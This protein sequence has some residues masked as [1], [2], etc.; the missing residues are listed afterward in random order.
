MTKPIMPLGAQSLTNLNR[1]SLE[2]Y[3]RFLEAFGGYLYYSRQCRTNVLTL[4]TN[5]LISSSYLFGWRW[6]TSR[7][8]S[9]TAAEEIST[10]SS[11]S[12]STPEEPWIEPS[13]VSKGNASL[14]RAITLRK[15]GKDS[16]LLISPES[17]QSGN[18]NACS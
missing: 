16:P 1:N 7:P 12:F 8:C 6:S 9:R 18:A 3:P 10:S 13:P 2:R 15:I 4:S 17:N 11:C 14:E 5:P